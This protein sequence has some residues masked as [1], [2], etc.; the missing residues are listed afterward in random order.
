[1]NAIAERESLSRRLVESVEAAFSHNGR[2]E[3]AFRIH[4]HCFVLRFA[5]EKIAKTMTRALNHLAIPEASNVSLTIDCW[6]V[7]GSGATLPLPEWPQELF[8][9]RGEVRWLDSPEM[10]VAYFD[11]IKLLNVYSPGSGRAFYCIADADSFPVQQLGSPALTIFSWWAGTLGWQFA[12]AA[13]VGTERGGVLVVG[14]GGAGKS[15]LVFSTLGS[16]LHYLSDDYC[17]LAPGQPPRAL[18]LYN[19]GK[20][21]EASLCLHQHLRRHAANADDLLREKAVFFLHEE[22]PGS[23]IYEAPL[24]AIVL[25][26]FNSFETSLTPAN[27]REVVDTLAESTLRQ[28]AGSDNADFLR[29][30]RVARSLPVYRLNHGLD[31]AETHKLLLQLCES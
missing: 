15:T 28:L 22:F 31:A 26:Q 10:R 23:L 2:I 18:A 21:T 11:W 19:S 25:P 9:P 5:G 27:W 14:H 20:L 30:M 24:R 1:M 29:M 16:P 7:A 13:A 3:R 6:D 17:I 4:G 12:H 8:T